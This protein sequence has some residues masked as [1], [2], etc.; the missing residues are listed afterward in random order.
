M[1][2]I[3]YETILVFVLAHPWITFYLMGSIVATGIVY[4][5]TLAGYLDPPNKKS[6]FLMAAS[7]SWIIV[8]GFLYGFLVGLVGVLF[9]ENNEGGQ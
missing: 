6:A 9:G 4:S 5:L 7:S 1:L 8:I 2:E 3:I